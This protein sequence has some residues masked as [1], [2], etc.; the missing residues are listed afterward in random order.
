MRRINPFQRI[1]D[2]CNTGDAKE[3]HR[4]LPWFP[5]IIDIEPTSACNFRCVFCPTG[6]RSIGRPT[7]F[8]EA[9]TFYSILAEC[10]PH[11]T[12]IRF[13]GWG[14]PLMHPDIVP[15]IRACT[16]VG[17]LTHINTNGSH[18]DEE[19]IEKLLDAGLSSIKLSFQGVDRDTYKEMRGTD[20]F[21]GL[22]R[23]IELMSKLRAC[24]PSP[25]IAVSTSTTYESEDMIREFTER[26][27]PLVDQISIG[28]TVFGFMDLRA[29]KLSDEDRKRFL[30]YA[31]EEQDHL[32]H[33]DPCPEVYDKLTIHQDGMAQVCCNSFG[34]QGALGRV[35]DNTIAKIWRHPVIEEYRERLARGEYSGP[36]CSQC[37]DYQGLTKGA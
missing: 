5:R 25:W 2:E 24:A 33:P 15:W 23:K 11:E 6:N 29:A 20:F 19:L 30:A 37:W 10:A 27:A 13:I 32:K 18:L 4:H 31:Q 28:K 21:H 14:E 36:L 16:D 7:G 26:L 35:P 8:M 3:K 22:I 34:N 9:S 1:Y 12:A 17:V